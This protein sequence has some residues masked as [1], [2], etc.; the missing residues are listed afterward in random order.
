MT[1]VFDCYSLSLNCIHQVHLLRKFFSLSE[2]LFRNL[3][4][5]AWQNSHYGQ[6][7]KVISTYS[8]PINH[9]MNCSCLIPLK[10]QME[11]LAHSAFLATDRL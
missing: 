5:H 11:L 8:L 6:P 2:I 10:L 1:Q 3:M 9:S 7:L 4:A